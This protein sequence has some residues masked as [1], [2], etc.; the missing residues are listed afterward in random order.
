MFLMAPCFFLPYLC[1]TFLPLHF[2][3]E[4][5]SPFFF[6]LDVTFF[7]E[8]R[9]Q[10]EKKKKRTLKK[11]F[12][13]IFH[14]REEKWD[15]DTHSRGR[16]RTPKVKGLPFR[17][18]MSCF[19]SPF[20]PLPNL[21]WNFFLANLINFWPFEYINIFVLVVSDY[22]PLWELILPYFLTRRMW[23]VLN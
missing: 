18:R 5:V 4:R 20:S 23:R 8:Y 7:S 14:D 1:L 21:P 22:F 3:V 16:H 19:Q 9:R 11:E 6:L 10:I 2:Q 13:S 15:R 12:S 17:H